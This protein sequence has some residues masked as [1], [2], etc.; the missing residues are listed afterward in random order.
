MQM[1]IILKRRSYTGAPAGSQYRLVSGLWQVKV[2]R[3]GANMF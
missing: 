1:K 3:D 2:A